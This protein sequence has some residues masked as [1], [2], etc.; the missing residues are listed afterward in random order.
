MNYNRDY[1]LPPNPDSI[2]IRD[3]PASHRY[4]S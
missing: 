1:Y 4:A 3:P 2:L